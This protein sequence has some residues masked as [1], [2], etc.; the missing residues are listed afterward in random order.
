MA[1]VTSKSNAAP[2]SGREPR[3]GGSG[4][5]SLRLREFE[6]N[7][8]ARRFYEKLGWSVTGERSRTTFPPYP[9]LLEYAYPL[10]Q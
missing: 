2:F 3:G 5:A 4:V 6:A 10:A 9:E 7:R 8:R 1:H